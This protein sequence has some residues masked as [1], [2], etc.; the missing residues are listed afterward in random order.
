MIRF[1]F[2]LPAFFSVSFCLSGL[3]LGGY[4]PGS[5]LRENLQDANPLN[6][7]GQEARKKHSKYVTVLTD[8]EPNL[9]AGRFVCLTL[10]LDRCPPTADL[11]LQVQINVDAQQTVLLFI[12]SINQSYWHFSGHICQIWIIWDSTDIPRLVQVWCIACTYNV[13]VKGSFVWHCRKATICPLV[14]KI[15][16]SVLTPVN[17]LHL[18]VGKNLSEKKV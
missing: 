9:F 18:S 12:N 5:R 17:S 15:T 4:N 1:C 6:F 11:F 7:P 13:F 8:C 10:I 3:L 2:L 16:L 14:R